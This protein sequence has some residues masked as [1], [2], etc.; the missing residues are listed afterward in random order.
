MTLQ[1]V[2]FVLQSTRE[3]FEVVARRFARCLCTCS[4]GRTSAGA[5]SVSISSSVAAA[6]GSIEF[7]SLG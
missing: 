5:S 2:V 1:I 4:R 3:I 7:S 6:T